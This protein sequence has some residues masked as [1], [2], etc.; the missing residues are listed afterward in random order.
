MAINSGE[1]D[2][3]WE[4]I[5]KIWDH[6]RSCLNSPVPGKKDWILFTTAV[7]LESC[8]DSK[9]NNMVFRKSVDDNI[10]LNLDKLHICNQSGRYLPNIRAAIENYLPL[11]F[12]KEHKLFPF[13]GLLRDVL[14]EKDPSDLDLLL[15]KDLKPT[16]S[17]LKDLGFHRIKYKQRALIKRH[18]IKD[19]LY[20][21]VSILIRNPFK[22]VIHLQNNS[23]SLLKRRLTPENKSVLN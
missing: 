11:E 3:R 14:H 8:S 4:L 17:S 5:K 22:H 19:P 1:P 9:R 20:K 7:E 18:L 2:I 10:R 16:L 6:P 23:G 21:T 12:L 15:T 13:G